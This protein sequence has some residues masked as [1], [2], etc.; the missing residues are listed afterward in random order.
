MPYIPVTYSVLSYDFS[1]KGFYDDTFKNDF[2]VLVGNDGFVI[3]EFGGIF[4]TRCDIHMELYPYDAQSCELI[5]GLWMY[6]DTFVNI[7]V[8][9]PLLNHKS[10]ENS[11]WQLEAN[12][13]TNQDR[14]FESYANARFAYTF[15]RKPLYYIVNLILPIIFLLIIAM[16]VFWLPAESGEKASLG[17][18]VLLASS[19]FQLILTSHIPVNSDVTPNISKCTLI[20]NASNISDTT[21]EALFNNN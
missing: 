15:K 17:I 12:T 16:G 2:K 13:F 8:L 19:V 6:T 9:N 11:L 18:T 10:F 5:L 14:V 7:S 21:H 3:W 20:V 4:I 1:V